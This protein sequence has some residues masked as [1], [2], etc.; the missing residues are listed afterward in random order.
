MN[1]KYRMSQVVFGRSKNLSMFGK[2][3]R[4]TAWLVTDKQRMDELV[5]KVHQHVDNIVELFPALE[6]EQ[7]QIAKQ[8][9]PQIVGQGINQDAELGRLLKSVAQTADPLLYSAIPG[10]IYNNID[11]TDN[12]RIQA[13]DQYFE[14]A[15]RSGQSGGNVYNGIKGSGSAWIH[16]GNS[17]GGGTNLFTGPPK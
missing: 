4:T 17:Y 9:V 3:K 8:E 6:K 13:G 1:L 7:K 5:T 15:Q 14:K 10:N 16:A 12:V 11:V 2:A